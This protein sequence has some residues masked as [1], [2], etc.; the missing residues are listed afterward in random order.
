MFFF[1]SMFCSF[2][3]IFKNGI[4]EKCF[5]ERDKKCLKK[6]TDFSVS[7][8]WFRRFWR[9][10]LSKQLTTFFDNILLKYQCGFR[11]G[12][13]TQ[14]CLLLMLEK[15]MKAQIT[16]QHFGILLTDLSKAFTCLNYE[17]LIAKLHEYGLSLSSLELVHDYF[18]NRKQRTKFNSKYSSWADISEAVPHGSVL[19][20]LFFDRF[21]CDLFI[22]LTQPTLPVMLLITRPMLLKIQ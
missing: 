4:C 12:H 21:L 19:W 9:E 11:K 20:P 1:I 13:C 15:W 18:L 17:L 10:F 2:S 14:H 6:T 7:C 22:M 3:I 5:Q 16:K 8:P